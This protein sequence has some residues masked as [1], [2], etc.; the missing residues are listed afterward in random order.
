MQAGPR[1][2]IRQS[3]QL[4]MTPRLQQ[5]IRL[6]QMSHLD[7][8][9]FIAE[10][11]E[12]NPVLVVDDGGGETAA[13]EASIAAREDVDHTIALGDHGA[14]E[15]SFGAREE[16]AF[17]E[18]EMRRAASLGGGPGLTGSADQI[19]NY[20]E[21]ASGAV[22]LRDHLLPQIGTSGAPREVRLL[23]SLLVDDL[24]EAGYLRADLTR[25]EARL[26]ARAGLAAAAVALLQSCEPTGIGARNLEECLALQLKE[27]NRFDP[28]MEALVANLPL[29]AAAR[30]PQLRAICGV[31]DEDLAEMI[32]ELRALDPRPGA[33]FTVDVAQAVV[34]DVFVRRSAPGG[35]LVE[36]NA[37]AMPKVLL[38]TAYLA[39]VGASGEVEIREFI[40]A[41]RR[42]ADWLIRALDQRA[43]TILKVAT[44]ITRRQAGFFETG[45]ARMEPMTLKQVADEIGMHE[46][47]VSRVT[48][49]KFL[50][51]ERGVFEMKFFFTAGLSAVA[52]GDTVSAAAVRHRI[53]RLIDQEDCAAVLSDERIAT[54]LKQDGVDVAR[55]TVAKYREAMN[56]PGSSQRRR[57]KAAALRR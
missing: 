32:A 50:S 24:D 48:A 39:R 20:E 45:V 42:D 51:C 21:T 30:L 26:G 35:W 7:A 38:D 25:L 19:G 28:A 2:E 49:N 52:G 16:H 54:I 43:Q 33:A 57:M 27:R 47:T 8:A 56:I 40:S 31:D 44:E 14:D 37:E 3:Q 6:L 4:V 11:L 53:K 15:P 10:E 13:P 23:A 12:R 41:C 34:P 46:S 17:D 18:T 1:L 36:V 9:A 29:L 55:R 5:A 22:T